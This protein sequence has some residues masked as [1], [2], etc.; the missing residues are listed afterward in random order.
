[1]TAVPNIT[2]GPTG[3]VAPSESQILTGTNADINA[4]FGGGLNMAQTT[5]Q[6]Q[7]SV[8]MAAIIGNV[9][10][11]FVNLAN[12]FDPAFAQGRFQDALARI[13]FLQRQPALPTTLNVVCSGLPN[14]VIPAGS[15]IMD[16]AGNTYVATQQGTIA[17]TGSVI[18]PFANLVAGPIAIPSSVS[19]FQAIVGWD[20]VSVS[21]GTLGQNVETRSAF[22]TRRQNAVAANSVGSVASIRGAVLNVPGVTDAYVT[23]N[24]SNGTATIGGVSIPPHSLY[25]AAVGGS[26][27]AVAQAIWSRKIPG[28]SYYPG[29]TTVTV[30]DQNSGYSPPF[31]SYQV[32]FQIPQ[33]LSIFFSI[34]LVQNTL[35]PA[36]AN[37]LIQAALASAFVGGDGGPKT[38]IGSTVIANRFVAPIEALGTWALVRFITVASPNDV[39]TNGATITGSISGSVLTVTAVSGASLIPFMFLTTGT[40]VGGTAVVAPGTF[41]I[42]QVSGST[43]GTGT[44]NISGIQ[45]IGAQTMIASSPVNLLTQVNINQSPFYNSF[46]V[47]ISAT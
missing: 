12:M 29:N 19:I 5:P 45:S 16:S 35:I 26:A 39:G 14:V 37:Q 24:S 43:G 47:L 38:S 25:V 15:Q 31:P 17:S 1:M 27:S 40:G 33:S 4:A 6:G 7:L 36:N 41:I 21:S 28:C 46:N 30:L 18:I 44:Y 22:E 42:S 32:S 2:I 20:S 9:Y 10:S 13:Y 8:S 23:E 34:N 11:Q 3:L